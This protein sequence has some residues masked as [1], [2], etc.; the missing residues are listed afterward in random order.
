M[1]PRRTQ[2]SGLAYFSNVCSASR[3]N[4]AQQKCKKWGVPALVVMPSCLPF[5]TCHHSLVMAFGHLS[6]HVRHHF[7]SS[8]SNSPWCDHEKELLCVRVEQPLNAIDR[9]W[10]PLSEYST[11][12]E[13][14]WVHGNAFQWMW[15]APKHPLS[16]Y[17]C[18]W[19]HIS[20]VRMHTSRLVNLTNL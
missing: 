17:E 13:C 2:L 5:R 4:L 20:K 12:L 19:V 14:Y 8:K 7:Q 18:L 10:V 1:F 11:P 16:V 3:I 15:T 6:G 9:L